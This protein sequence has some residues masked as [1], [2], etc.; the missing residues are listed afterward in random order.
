MATIT[1]TGLGSGLDVESIVTQL[2]EIEREPLNV[3]SRQKDLI[4]AQ[5]SAYGQ[6]KSTM[7]SFQSAMNELADRNKFNK[8]IP[9]S[10]DE[11]VATATSSSNSAARGLYRLDVSRLAQNHK[12]G[13]D[14]VAETDTF[15]GGAGDTLNFTV[16]ENSMALDMSTAMTLNELRDAINQADDNPGVAAAVLNTGDGNQR[17]ILTADQ[18]GFDDRIQLSYGG[19]IAAGTFNF[20]TNNRDSEGAVYTNLEDLDAA[21]TL[22]GY[23]L[24]ANSNS[25]SDAIS[26]I[27]FELEG[28]GTA[29]LSFDRDDAA[30]LESIQAFADAY[31]SVR[32]T[33]DELR[34]N[35]LEAE[36]PLLS[37]EAQINGVINTP[38]SF[39]EGEFAY[40]AEVGLSIDKQGRMQVDS[41]R[42]SAAL[43]TDFNSVVS[44]FADTEEGF[45][46]RL[47]SVAG[48]IVGF[49]GLLDIRTD[50]LNERIS[51][52]DSR[53]ER[54]ELRLITTERRIRAQFTALDGLVANL[55]STGSFL[56]QQLSSLNNREG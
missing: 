21:F 9:S 3:I 19:G 8:F 26:G 17:L 12:M 46:E 28:L 4:N 13:S 41:G 45:A 54:I 48:N 51:S 56:T 50:G 25:V 23:A 32:S 29:D 27:T 36:A 35:E 24:T 14:E 2:M 22:D 34:L 1:A 38:A 42:L 33:I 15:G 20:A 5:I 49:G 30:I 7:S 16:G 39:A 43:D 44:L 55:Q 47:Q 18:S 31:N 11:D 10:S 40:L 53:E 52:L 37:I 6:L